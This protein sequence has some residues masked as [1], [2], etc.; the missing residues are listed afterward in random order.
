MKQEDKQQKRCKGKNGVEI[1]AES[2]V[3]GWQ[4]MRG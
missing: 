4:R 2:R 3:E 1:K